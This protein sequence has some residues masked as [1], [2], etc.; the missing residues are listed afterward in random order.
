MK[1]IIKVLLVI[2]VFFI[3]LPVFADTSIH[4]EIK[5][6]TNI[7]YD[8]DITV[9]PCDSDNPT[10]GN[11][12]ET[13]YC[14]IL[15]SGV[16]TDWNFAWAPGIFLNS[17]NEITGFTTKD[18]Q[19]VDVY[20]YWN[21]SA[22]GIDGIT[23]L[24]E[25]ILQPN[26]TILLNFID[27]QP[28]PEP[29]P[30][31]KPHHSSGGSYVKPIEQK[32]IFDAKKALDYLVSQQ[33]E[34]GSFDEEIYTDWTSIAF[35]SNS[36]YQ[37]QK[38]KL[39]EYF[40]ENKFLGTLFTDYERHTM[41]LMSLN[42]NPYNLNGENYIQKIISN[43]DGTQFGDKEK[44]ND[45]IFALIVLQNAGFTKDDI[46]I[47]KTINF[48]LSKQKEDGS[49]DENVDITGA[50]IESLAKFNENNKIKTALEKA[51]NYLKQKQ[52]VNGSWENISSTSWAIGGLLA[53]GEKIENSTLEYFGEN[54]DADGGI[55][56]ENVK[57]KIWQTSYAITATSGKTWNEI[58]QKFEKLTIPNLKNTNNS[59][60]IKFIKKIQKFQKTVPVIET[61]QNQE[62]TLP[63]P[64][65]KKNIFRR[66][67]EA[68]FGF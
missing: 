39:I 32:P 14:A 12:K 24:N 68:L 23:G 52:N 22:N 58:M 64:V 50:G 7:I 41:A 4:L 45:D 63:A 47:Q 66:I 16:Q 51:K 67:F 29:K 30:A 2:A 6:P 13:A 10:S 36:D 37:Y 59:N 57:N 46:Q 1:K 27:P 43:F 62:Q 56:N 9:V 61:K 31:P 44:D 60:Q 55:K 18:N 34:N 15:Q 38:A 54:Q 25:Y 19:G 42:L 20:H 17:I 5:T 33:K 11:L 3:S 28:E 49:W 35:A 65:N 53:L 26:D 8:Q 40:S 21:W 48:I